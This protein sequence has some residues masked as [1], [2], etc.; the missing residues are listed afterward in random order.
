MI[1][2][3]YF[4]RV[5]RIFPTFLSFDLVNADLVVDHFATFDDAE[6]VVKSFDATIVDIES[7]VRFQ[8]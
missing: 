5:K 2:H 3:R 7:D 8:I 4:K 6:N 1:I